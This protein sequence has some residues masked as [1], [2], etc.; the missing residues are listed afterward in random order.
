MIAELARFS[1]GRV[2]LHLIAILG[3]RAVRFHAAIE[4]GARAHVVA[5]R[6]GRSNSLMS[7]D[8]GTRT[9]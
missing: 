5:W 7:S 9:R 8:T 4:N 1:L 2:F 6:L 3:D